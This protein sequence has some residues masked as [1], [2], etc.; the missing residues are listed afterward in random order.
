MTKYKGRDGRF[1]I[2]ANTVA[3]VRSFRFTRTSTRA[4]TS[5]LEDEW[6]AND[7]VTKSWSGQSLVWWD[8]SD[9]NGQGGLKEGDRPTG[10]LYP[11]G[12]DAGKTYFSGT[13]H[14]DSVE[15][16]NERDGIVEATIQWTGSGPC[17]E[18]V[19]GA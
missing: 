8:P 10:F 2:G 12:T 4:D 18:A 1:K 5:T 3:Q 13:L 17:T 11:Q 7:G 14:V 19:V 6:D 15:I 16:V 9:A